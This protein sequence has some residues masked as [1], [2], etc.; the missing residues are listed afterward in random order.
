MEYAATDGRHEIGYVN[1]KDAAA[2]YASPVT[3]TPEGAS[4]T[5]TLWGIFVITHRFPERPFLLRGGYENGE[6]AEMH[7]KKLLKR[8]GHKV[9]DERLKVI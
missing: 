5:V 8:C 3:F 6:V 9:M 1:L 7:L 4:M 2:V